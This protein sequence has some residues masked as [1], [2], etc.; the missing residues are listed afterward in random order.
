MR[1]LMV[2]P[3]QI[4]PCAVFQLRGGSENYA[5]RAFALIAFHEGFHKSV[6]VRGTDRK[7]LAFYPGIFKNFM[8]PR[9]LLIALVFTLN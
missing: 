5:I 7:P 1:A 9:K 6:K 2:V 8:V 3:F 4:F